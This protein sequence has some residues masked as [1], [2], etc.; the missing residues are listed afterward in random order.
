VYQQ[1]YNSFLELAGAQAA[2][3]TKKKI[4]IRT[5]TRTHHKRTATTDPQEHPRLQKLTRPTHN[6]N[7]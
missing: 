1:I 3:T 6:I 5:V 4:W 7:P 2:A